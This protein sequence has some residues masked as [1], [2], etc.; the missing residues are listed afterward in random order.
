MSTQN[1][2][3]TLVGLAFLVLGYFMTANENVARWGLSVGRGRIWV[4]LLGM[5]RAMKLTRFFFG[6][7]V[8]VLGVLTL[9]I[10]LAGR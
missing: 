3:M 4:A 7:L 1:I 9:L 5:E 8:M 10:V 6:P 2:V